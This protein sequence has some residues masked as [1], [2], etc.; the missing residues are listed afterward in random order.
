VAHRL[1]LGTSDAGAVTVAWA[2]ADDADAAETSA[3]ALLPAAAQVVA[4]RRDEAATVFPLAV[5]EHE[6][7]YRQALAS[8]LWSQRLY[9]WDGSS[10]WIPEW[11]G[12]VAADDVLIMPDPWE[13]PWLATWDSAFHAVTAALVDPELGA[14]QL[15]FILS[16]DWQ[17]PDGHISCAE[18]VMADECPPVF[19][20]AALRVH[21]AGA[22]TG[23][24]EEVYPGLVANHE[25][26]RREL[27]V[28][29]GLY[30]GGFLGMDNLPRAAGQAQ[31]D[32]SGWMAFSARQLAEIAE[33]LGEAEAAAAY[34][35]EV[36]TIAA[37]VNARLWDDARGFYYDRDEDGASPILTKSYSGLVPL[38]AGIVPDERAERLLAA[39]RDPSQFLSP[40]GIRSTSRDSVLYRPGYAGQ[41]GVNSSWRGA[42]WLPINYLLVGTLDELDPAF[43]ADLRE[44]LVELVET[45]W[46]A[47]GRFHE[48]FHADSGEGLGADAQ[49]GW[50]AL[51]ANLVV[52][53][54][55]AD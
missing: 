2:E 20:W 53:G 3:R 35:A 55:P 31:A 38:I 46:E 21:D 39:L 33:L 17:Q 51:V 27:Q 47:T 14:D 5:T 32:A 13:F 25:Y 54:W 34:R 1:T 37:A 19:S 45:D 8:L 22:G 26:W 49:A 42:I 48:Y 24:L 12:R 50:T 10:S 16:G 9:R 18:F 40:H 36:E 4:E 23:F 6:P 15:R 44:R 7:V 30:T 41:P 11:E 28:E 29:P 43:A 52:E